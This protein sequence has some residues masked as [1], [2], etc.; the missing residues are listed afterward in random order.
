MDKIVIFDWGGV[1]ESHKD[2]EYNISEAIKD[3]MKKYNCKLSDEEIIEKY[4]ECNAM[5][6]NE[7]I[8]STSEQTKLE[9]WFTKVKTTLGLNCELD[10]FVNSY[11]EEHKKIF[12]YKDV[13]NYAHSLKNKCKI[14]IF[15]N[16]MKLDEKRINEQVDLSKFDNVFLSFDIGCI[17]PENSAYEIVEQK[18]NIEPKNIFF[19]DDSKENINVAKSRGWQTCNAFGYE[20]DKIKEA[21]NTFLEIKN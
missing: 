9:N 1:I 13:V 2:G 14:G 7:S 20:L 19:I 12:Y 17:K 11:Y 3:L 15:S 16:L 6:C 5:K 18:T 4:S 21:V 10:E 8:C